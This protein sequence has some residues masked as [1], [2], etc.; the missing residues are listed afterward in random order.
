MI[1][2][3]SDLWQVG[4]FLR[5]LQ[6]PPPIKHDLHEIIKVVLKVAFNII[7][8]NPKWGI[9]LHEDEWCTWIVSQHQWTVWTLSRYQVEQKSSDN[10]HSHHTCIHVVIAL[11]GTYNKLTDCLC[12]RDSD[13]VWK[14]KRLIYCKMSQVI[15]PT[16]LQCFVKRSMHNIIWSFMIYMANNKHNLDKVRLLKAYVARDGLRK[17]RNRQFR[18]HRITSYLFIHGTFFVV[19]IF[20]FYR[21]YR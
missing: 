10:I 17:Y 14:S 20:I 6:F 12:V 1:K 7:I 19:V 18:C 8:P 9:H 2:L 21:H 4:G 13:F 15:E 3:V 16:L 11:L 5:V